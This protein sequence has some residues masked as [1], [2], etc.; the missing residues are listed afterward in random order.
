MRDGGDA[1]GN[2]G[3][4]EKAAIGEED[5]EAMIALDHEA[6]VPP[7]LGP[8]MGK[9]ELTPLAKTDPLVMV[10]ELSGAA[11]APKFTGF[12]V[13]NAPD[14]EPGAGEERGYWGQKSG[15]IICS[16]LHGQAAGKVLPVR[17]VSASASMTASS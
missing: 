14:D 6:I 16:K 3:T 2:I 9:N 12:Q 5:A 4:V 15:S 17:P 7:R 8:R 10:R 13:A 1:L 11:Q